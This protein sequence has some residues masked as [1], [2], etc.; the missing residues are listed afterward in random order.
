MTEVDVD[1]ALEVDIEMW[2][3]EIEL[4]VCFMVLGIQFFLG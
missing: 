3:H 1:V 4:G 2:V